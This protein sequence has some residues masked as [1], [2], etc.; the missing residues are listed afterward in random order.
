MPVM[1]T[2]ALVVTLAE[3]LHKPS[4]KLNPSR[5]T[6]Y[7]ALPACHPRDPPWESTAVR[8]ISSLEGRC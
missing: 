5:F 3:L 4:Q 8:A 7:A 1:Y 2:P 6:A